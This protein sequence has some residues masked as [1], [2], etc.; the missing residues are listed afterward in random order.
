MCALYT[1]D[2]I[3]VQ[4][5]TGEC[6]IDLCFGD[7][8]SLKKE[9]AVDVCLVSAFPGDYAATPTSLIGAFQKNLG[10]SV[11]ELSRDKEEDLRR[12]YCCWWSRPLPQRYPFRR[13]LCFESTRLSYLYA[14]PVELVGDVFRCLVPILR[15][16]DGQVITPLLATGDQGYSETV[17]LKGMID[18]A[19]NWMKAGLPL[20]LLKI[21]VF[22]RSV[23]EGK[24]DSANKKHF[25]GILSLFT[26]LK[27]QYESKE[28][29]EKNDTIEFDVYIS[30]SEKD[31]GV[32]DTIQGLLMKE[33]K[34]IK[35]FSEQQDLD[36]TCVWQENMYKVMVKCAKI[37]TVLSPAYLT[38][39]TCTEQYNIAL[40]VNRKTN[41]DRLAPF[42][43]EQIELLPSYM[44]LVQYVNCSPHDKLKL[45]TACHQVIV[46]LTLEVTMVTQKGQ[47]IKK[48]SDLNYDVFISYSHKNSQ[49]ATAVLNKLTNLN[50]DL[51]IFFDKEELK[52][53]HI[54]DIA[55]EFTSVKMVDG[56]RNDFHSV[57]DVTC[58][59]IDEMYADCNIAHL[60]EE[61]RLVK[62]RSKYGNKD[63]FTEIAAA[64]TD[65]GNK[66]YDIILSYA[67]SDAMYAKFF[68]AVIRRRAP[69]L[70]LIDAVS[71]D[72]R[73]M[74]V[75]DSASVIVP[76]ISPA[77][78]ESNQV[79]EL[80]IALS[81]HRLAH[82]ESTLFPILLNYLP[83][84]PTYFHLLPYEVSCVDE[85]WREQV[86]NDHFVIPDVGVTLG[87]AES[88]LLPAVSKVAACALMKAVDILLLR[89]NRQQPTMS[90]TQ[91]VVLCNV[92]KLRHE[93]LATQN[94]EFVA[95]AEKFLLDSVKETET[96]ETKDKTGESSSRLDIVDRSVTV[97]ESGTDKQTSPPSER[98]AKSGEE[99]NE[100]NWAMMDI[101]AHQGASTTVATASLDIVTS[102]N[103]TSDESNV[104]EHPTAQ[105]SLS[106][107]PQEVVQRRSVACHLL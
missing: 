93:I 65:L 35:I 88:S 29:E 104:S 8:T 47:S 84:K 44:G 74:A 46:A 20:R 23:K 97:E 32:V 86:R 102:K 105:N 63:T 83:Q 100:D 15:N 38:S 101:I 62:Y 10:L 24:M 92:V 1:E 19:V 54:E 49:Q 89:L 99:S 77:Y 67:P 42:Y 16:Q 79:V 31:L 69:S 78:V 71:T 98:K 40:C 2:T 37:I 51:K 28:I 43:V 57:V 30:Y 3:R 58:T 13:I 6:K 87:K 90:G 12:L 73:Q 95:R 48:R 75:L 55:E 45:A 85:H 25:K 96:M 11:R 50:P 7:I 68:R 17:M 5:E 94:A 106:A 4:T 66:S 60:T 72:H 39:A 36:T 52:T 9:E 53:E 103:E 34:D 64:E 59:D 91:N 41:R 21:V 33:K 56:F 22:T 76:L 26:A 14:H 107:T 81:R 80:Q 82:D 18:A 61:Y 27:E 70:K